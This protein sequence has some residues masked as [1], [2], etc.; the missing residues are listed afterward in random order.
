MFNKML[1]SLLFLVTTSA[2]AFHFPE[3][4]IE[5]VDET[6]IVAFVPADDLAAAGIWMPFDSTPPLSM[7]DAL[8]AV[9]SQIESEPKLAEARLQNIVL[10]P[11]P[12]HEQQWHYVAKLTTVNGEH[13]EDHYLLVLMNGKVI[14]AMG[15]PD[16]I[17]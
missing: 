12:H 10:A 11:I 1:I 5:Y 6:R 14:A 17:K 9:K 15:E 2:Q 3:E 8:S 16:S 13:S 7:T 4:L